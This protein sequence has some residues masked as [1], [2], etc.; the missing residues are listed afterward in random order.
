MPLLLENFFSYEFYELPELTLGYLA[1]IPDLLGPQ[2]IFQIC[3]LSKFL[4]VCQRKFNLYAF[5][6]F[7]FT[8]KLIKI[9]LC[10]SFL[11]SKRNY[12]APKVP[13]RYTTEIKIFSLLYVPFKILMCIL[14]NQNNKQI[15]FPFL[16][17]LE[18]SVFWL[19]LIVNK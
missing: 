12:K 9:L 5:H 10:E 18:F 13:R 6:L 7:T 17:L 2:H 8:L 3:F 15:A 1:H 14:S 11:N 16:S 4:H 19:I